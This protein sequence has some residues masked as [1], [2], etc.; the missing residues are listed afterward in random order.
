MVE[1][2]PY[3]VCFLSCMGAHFHAVELDNTIWFSTHSR[4]SGFLWHS[5]ESACQFGHFLQYMS[6]LEV[7]TCSLCTNLNYVITM[8]QQHPSLLSHQVKLWKLLKERCSNFLSRFSK[9]DTLPQQC[10]L[11]GQRSSAEFPA[12]CIN[13]LDKIPKIPS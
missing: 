8:L 10:S 9:T 7:L 6:G 13:S 11:L 1:V 2:L 4:M 5:S 3:S 12:K